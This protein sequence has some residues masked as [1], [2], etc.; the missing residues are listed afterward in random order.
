MVLAA[1][2]AATKTALKAAKAALDVSDH[3]EAV[4][5]ANVVIAADAQNYY[6]YAALYLSL[7]PRHI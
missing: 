2:M 7:P 5:Q 6:G 1:F 3:K 4:K